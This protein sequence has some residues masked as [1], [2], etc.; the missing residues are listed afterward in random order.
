[1]LDVTKFV[2][3]MQD[4][5]ARAVQP[6][7]SRIKALEDRQPEKGDDGNPGKDG[8]P[9][10]DGKSFTIEEA[11]NLLETKMAQW[12][13]DFERRAYATLE[14]A[15]DRIQPAKDGEPG[16]DGRDGIGF[17]DL[18][19]DYDGERSVTIKFT[20]GDKIKEFPI[21]LPSMIYRGQYEADKSY[22]QNDTV[23]MGG[24]VWIAQKDSPESRPGTNEG[25]WK[26]AVKKG[27][28][29]SRYVEKPSE[30]DPS[31]SVK[32]NSHD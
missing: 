1:M 13:L 14:K 16:K 25:E 29:V 22:E 7:V 31:A 5:I 26:L 17:D 19:V 11:E 6:L 12:A 23:T 32:L 3:E 9:G 2:T 30:R 8:E 27:R 21:R 28:D 10:K 24:S 4:Y 15:A 20:K 18:T